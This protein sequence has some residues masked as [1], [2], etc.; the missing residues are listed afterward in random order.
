MILLWLGRSHRS[1]PGELQEL[2]RA[3]L[4]AQPAM[5]PIVR[6]A[7]ECLRAGHDKSAR[8]LSTRLRNFLA[9]VESGPTEIGRRFHRALPARKKN[10][11]LTHSYSGTVVRALTTA[12]SRIDR[13]LC[14][15][16]R[17]NYE[18]RRM[19]REL[20]SAGVKAELMTDSAI[21]EFVGLATA[22]VVGADAVSEGGMR[23]KVGTAAL[24]ACALQQHVPIWV[25]A[26]TSKLLPHA[27]CDGREKLAVN[28]SSPQEVWPRSPARIRVLNPYF[29]WTRFR[30]GIRILTEAGWIT[31]RDLR[32]R[33]ARLHLPKSWPG[34][35]D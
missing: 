9:V 22:V 23:N 20:T 13:V 6:I 24:V 32:R 28:D 18:G 5:A 3:V 25:L 31:S 26:D 10:V 15:E 1:S 17:P 12:R 8:P 35:F 33:I 4:R 34:G 19:A 14:S 16:G 2:A 11:L 21:T 29:G 7:I 30:R 27:L